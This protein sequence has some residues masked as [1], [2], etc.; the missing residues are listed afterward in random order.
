V[1][2]VDLG[3][4]ANPNQWL[5]CSASSPPRV[6]SVRP[7]P[8]VQRL[9]VISELSIPLRTA[10]RLNQEAGRLH[11]A[12]VFVGKMTFG[13]FPSRPAGL[14]FSAQARLRPY[15]GSFAMVI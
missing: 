7:A 5:T 13:S 9:I 2:V 14:S 8:P 6:R 10:E 12:F 11:A 15:G 4:S 3:G 1:H